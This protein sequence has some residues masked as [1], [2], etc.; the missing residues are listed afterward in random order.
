MKVAEALME[1]FAV[2]HGR[3]GEFSQ[4]ALEVA[5]Y[6][7]TKAECGGMSFA[8]AFEA[9]R[10]AYFSH[11]NHEVAATGSRLQVS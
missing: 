1:W 3:G 6:A 9:G 8:E 7:A 4:A 2:H 5:G 10:T 11:L